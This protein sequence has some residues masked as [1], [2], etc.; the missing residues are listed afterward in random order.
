MRSFQSQYTKCQK[1]AQ[2]TGAEA[3]EFF[4]S[5]LNEGQ[6][7]LEADLGS[8]YTE[9]TDISNVTVANSNSYKTPDQ[10]VRLKELYVTVGTQRYNMEQI[11]DEVQWQRFMQTN[12]KADAARFCF[13][14]RDRFEVYP[15]PSSSSNVITMIYEASGK[16]LSYDDYVTGSIVSVANGGTAVVGVG[17]TW[18]SAMIGRYIKITSYP[19]WYK[20]S[21]VGS[22]TTLTLDK[23]F[24]GISIAAATEAYTIGEMPRTPESTH[25]IPIWYAMMNYYQG[26]KQSTEKAKRFETLYD[27]QT[28]WAK[29]TYGKRYSSNYIPGRRSRAAAVNPNNYPQNLTY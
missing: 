17:T 27:K 13:I 22:N 26:F 15:T 25:Q 16:E 3:L 10:F 24:S 29:L 11:F 2:D 5:T 1:L 19:I 12:S 4:K 14:R 21:A 23:P 9:E 7:I 28:A 8:Y 18:T 20:I 6:H